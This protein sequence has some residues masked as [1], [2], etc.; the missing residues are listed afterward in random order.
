M[1]SPIPV[2]TRPST[3]QQLGERDQRVVYK[4]EQIGE[5]IQTES[6]LKDNVKVEIMGE[7]AEHTLEQKHGYTKIVAQQ[8]PHHEAV[9]FLQISRQYFTR[10]LG[11]S[12]IKGNIFSVSFYSEKVYPTRQ[13]STSCTNRKYLSV[14]I[15]QIV[16]SL[17]SFQTKISRR[18][19]CYIILCVELILMS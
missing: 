10:N 8:T 3:G 16:V 4:T 13:T 2:T 11:F 17:I 9:S 7:K 15:Q 18:C 19:L 5:G 14:L 1:T 6:L 12:L